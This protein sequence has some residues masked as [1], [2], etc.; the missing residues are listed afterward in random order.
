[1]K[2]LFTFFCLSVVLAL[3]SKAQ[4]VTVA[5][6][7]GAANG[8]YATLKSAFDALN[9]VTT[10]AGNIITVSITG[11]TTEVASAALNQPSVSSWTS[12]T[13][14]PSGGAARTVSGAITG[15]LIDLNGTQN[16][17]VNGLNTG[18]NSLNISNIGIGASSTIRLAADASNNTVTNC[19]LE[20]ST[21]VFGVV[22]LG[23]G[24][25]TGNDGNIISSNNI[26]PAGAN[27][28]LNGI[29]SLGT[30]AVIDNSGNTITA[31]NI[32]DYFSATSATN[33]MN[34]N[35]FNSAWTITN[36]RL[37]QTSSRLYTTAS[38]HNGINITSG[39]NY[40]ITGNI[41]GFAN[42]AGTGTT[43]MVGNTVTL[44]GTFPSSY[45]TTG[46]ANATRYVAINCAFTAG[47][48]VSSIQNN[49][50]AG[51]AL[52]T[53]S[54]ATT[55]NG[56][57]CGINVTSGN[58]DIGT[59]AGNT[60]GSTSGTGSIYTAC[61]TSGG[62]VVGIY[63]STTNTISIQNNTIGA[64]DAMGTTSSI[65]GGFNGIN[66]AGTGGNFDIS[67]NTIGNNT[68]PNI[69]TGNL[70]TGANL[71]NVGTTNGLVTGTGVGKVQGIF[72]AAS[73]IVII[74]TPAKPNTIRNMFQNSSGTATSSS[75]VGI[76][77]TAS[78]T[79]TISNNSI[80]N[81]AGM[82]AYATLSNG[83]ASAM[84]IMVRGGAVSGSTII[85]NTI[86]NIAMNN[87]GAIGT[88]VLGIAIAA[89][90]N[91]VVT[92]NRIY[93]LINLSTS[94]TA[95]APGAA[96]GI[97][98]RSGAVTG[99]PVNINNNMISLGNAQTTNTSFIGIWGQ[100]G[101]TP[102]PINNIYFNSVNIEGTVAAGAQ[103]SFCFYRGDFTITARV[104]AVDIRNNIFQNTRTGG[105]GGHYA[106]SNGFGATTTSATGWAANASNYNVL[107]AAA[108]SIGFWTTAQTFAGWQA[109]SASDANSISGPV[110]N[111]VSTPTADLHILFPPSSVIE[112]AGILIAA[113]TDDFDGQTRSTLSPTDIGADAGNFVTAGLNMGAEALVTPAVAANGCY[114]STETVTIRIRN[115][116]INPINFVTN[117]VTVTT[118]V[119]GAATQTLSAV[120]NTGTLGAGLSMDVPMVGTLNMTPTGVY[121]FNAFTAVTG[122]TNP[123]NDAMTPVNLTKAALAAGSAS[124]SPGSYCITGGTPTLTTTG[125]TGYGGLQWQEST[126]PSVGF[127]NISG[128]TTNPFTL[129][130]PITQTMYYRLQTS[131]N[132][133]TVTSNEVTVILNNPQITS[134]TPGA[135][136]GPGPVT[137]S[138]AAT[139]TGTV[140]NWYDVPSGGVSIGTGSPF[141]TPPI[142]VNTPYYVSASDGGGTAGLGLPAQIAG[143][144]GA[145]T[146]NFGLVFDA[147]A[148]FTLST[149]V[150][151]P[152][153]SAAG[154]AGTVTIDV[155]NSAGA[156][157]NT[158]TVAVVGNPVA[159]ATAQTVTLNF[160][161]LAGTNLKLRPG[162][163]SAGITGLLFEPSAGAPPGGNY[164]YPFVLSGVV[165]INHSTLTAPPTNT[166]RLDLYYYF[167]NWQII[168]G[169]ESARTSV[170]ASVTTPPA[171]TISYAGTPYCSNAGTATVTQTGTTGGT[172]SAAPA[173][174][175]INASTGDITL[176]TSTAGTYTVTYTIAAAG[177]CPVFTTTSS[178]T[179]T[180]ATAATISYA[181]SPY[182]TAGG[183]ATVTQTGTAGGT[184]SS[185]AGLTINGSTGDVTLGTSTPGTYT[186]TYTIA[187]AGGCAQFMTT[188]SITIAADNTITFTSA[189][190]TDAQTVCINTA[191]T[192][193]T[194]AT[195]GATGATF[196]G[197]PAGVTG[198]WA[199]NVA[200][201]SGSPTTTVGSPFSYTVTLT[202]GCGTLSANGT[203]TVNPDNTITLTSIP[204]TD[205]QSVC[206]NTPIT[207]IT[208]STTGATG[209]TFTGLPAGVTGSWAANV[210]TISG[211]PT[212]TVGS[213]FNYT[214]TLT[215]G[216]GV[217]TATGSIT[218]RPLPVINSTQL[219]PTTCAS[220]DGSIDI[221]VSGAA[222]PYTYAWT[223]SG[224]NP[225]SEDQTGLTVG[226]YS[227]TATAANG[228]TT[229]A[230]FGL[231]GPGGCSICPTIGSFT[232]NPSGASCSG[233]PLTLTASGLTDMGT[234][235]GIIFKQSASALPDPYVGGTVVA[236]IPNGALTSGGTVATTSTTL[237]TGSY[238]IYAILTPTPVDPVCRPSAL[239]NHTVGATPTV[240]QPA[241][242]VVC[243]NTAT[244]PVN[245]TGTPFGTICGTANEGGSV[246]LTAPVGSVI[247]N[248]VFASYGT[249]NGV[250]GSFTLGGCHAAN[251]VSIV[252]GLAVGQ[253][254]VIIPADNAIFGDPCGGTPKRLYI[255]AQYSSVVFNWT[256]SNPSIGLAASGTGNIPSF[257]ATN[258]TTSPVVATVT[259]TPE[260]SSAGSSTSI[261]MPPQSAIFASNARGYW[262]IAPV[263]FTI[264][265]LFVPTDASAGNQSIAVVR[266]DGNTPPPVFSTVTNA[267]STLF[268]TQND[269]TPGNIAVT[270]P[271]N[272][273]EVIGILGSRG[274]TSS[275]GNGSSGI[276]IAGNP[277]A[278]TRMGMQFPLT[279]TTPQDLWQ[280]PS[281]T[282]ISRVFFGYSLTGITCPGSSKTFTITVNPTPA[283]TISYTGS[284]YC[285]NA[286]TAT[287]TQ[288]GTAG[289]T[290]SAAPAGLILNAAN[291]D[292]TLGTST[293]GTYTVTYTIAA[294]GGCPS[295]TATTSITITALPAATINYAGNPYCSNAGTA[296]VT[297][298]GTAGGTYSA[299]PA[300]L[301]LNA[302]TGNV[303]LGTSTPGTY[304][305]TYTIAA[306]GGCPAVTATTSI[307]ITA[308][309]A[310]TINYAGSPYCTSS[311]TATVTRTGIAGGT[312]TAT[313]AGLTL[314][315][316]TG[317]VT[318]ATSA[319]GTYTVTYT[320]AASGGCP[321]VTATASITV[322][323]A[324]AATIS[325]AGTPYC[326][327][328]PSAPV[329]RTGAAG[330]TYTAAPAGLT[331]NAS[332]GTVTPNTS[333]PGT[334]TVT[335]SMVA[336][337]G[338]PA[339]TATTSIT[340][341]QAPNMIIF[342]AGTPYCSNAGT[343]T[344]T[345]FGTAGGTYSA[346]P[347]GL[348]INATTGA[349]TLGTSTPG[350][351]TVTY[352][353]TVPGC[354]TT[355]T[356]T[357][358]TITA[359]PNATI[360]YAGS[361]YCSNGGTAA[362]TQTGTAGGTYSSTAGLTLNATTGAVTLG[363]SIPGTYTVTYTVAA[364]GGCAAFATTTT[365]T[366]TALPAAT[367]AYTGSPYCQNAGTANVT[368]AGT[369][370]GTYT[371]AAG[372]SINA[373]TGAVNLAASTAGT[374][375]VTYTLAA[376]G[377]CPA[378]T[379]TTTITITTLPAATIT[380]A[381]NPYCANGGTATVTRTGTAGGTYT[382]A[383]AGLGINV[384]TGAVTL[385]TSTPGTYT[386]TY[387]IA[388]GGG[389]G[390]VTAT[391]SIT[392]NALSVDPTGATASSTTICG[393]GTV[394]LNVTGGSLGGG[395]TWRWYSGSC[396][397]TLVG[398]GATLNVTVNATTTYFV[399]AEGT[400]N[401]TACASA[402]VTV[403]TQP[404]ISISA[405]AI[406]LVFPQ[407][408]TLTATVVPA[409]TPV[410]WFRNGVQVPGATGTT[411][412]VSADAVGTY[413]ARATTA[414]SCTAL[415]NA[416]TITAGV[417]DE[418]FIYPNPNNGQFTVKYHSSAQQLG[419]NRRLI[420]YNESGQFVY[421]EIFVVT[422]PYSS[423]P[424][425][426]R[427]LAKGFYTLRVTDA[428]GNILATGKVITQ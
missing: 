86:N 347:A 191:I 360:S 308:L 396:G 246:T 21:T 412:V 291:G 62:I 30:S 327:S 352:S 185:T 292:V 258:V 190:G 365:I 385:G 226:S 367:I 381:A 48:T 161:I 93:N 105:T 112:A 293:P 363:T 126:T 247:T 322:T 228:C 248:I 65:T 182:C 344:V 305:V 84:G 15:H 36:N 162:S 20:G 79:I 339:A 140:L 53:S 50:I 298:T 332:T 113:I 372:L 260:I 266:F 35:S 392:V 9:L 4:N 362:V 277:V 23:T 68:N 115:S 290:Y 33:G 356:T 214:V 60:I 202:G 81:L 180:A 17:T 216:C 136:C 306:S 38:T 165:S 104:A 320:I 376:G 46:T 285:S 423:M 189:P 8:S 168:T 148:P 155:V 386:V 215:G 317:D 295:V 373:A 138:L 132:G 129:A 299:A 238:F 144:S 211:T 331:I 364:S 135:S 58:A 69:R 100:H 96:C 177:G 146:T 40:T 400:C 265:S 26:G 19:T 284:P 11:N 371:A 22:Y 393:S 111:F 6:S 304:T 297:R 236:T 380:Y 141:T 257:T 243:N 114:T 405:S 151:Y 90:T 278:T 410:V 272:A 150:V 273:G 330:G 85:S 357:T 106:I 5:G 119:T 196:T 418:L 321:A 303:T 167:Y 389:C 109:A 345:R 323:A 427:N 91:I 241:N 125:A 7:G 222:G 375:T 336:S 399:R 313:P 18:G 199:A 171:A 408:S 142:S 287:V 108:S 249:P 102:D 29:Y 97:L 250:C 378:V 193:I 279:T 32:F 311:G 359:A 366:I 416:V 31:N 310:A 254:S 164:G 34:I 210:V 200:T 47:G 44:T 41:I 220:A 174:L 382:A 120:V 263:N 173:G 280:E 194:Y 72:N 384:T 163:R 74:G 66:S 361:P 24:I 245:F 282:N 231:A 394:T 267:F 302:A 156:V 130:S 170:I 340:I 188:T 414:L 312:Y 348:T 424:V 326:S 350:T 233:N 95:T 80:T 342:Y 39:V 283:A 49:T 419:F 420:I 406:N 51:F 186:V 397:G 110:V 160:N 390:V 218:V 137:V 149:V 99:T 275:Y 401:N 221:T 338:C 355:I 145:G 335:Y 242:Q 259:V 244:A 103:P 351:Y 425:D 169:C 403:N 124:V 64:I 404:T 337:G 235:Y 349:V 181:G 133:N 294:S 82:N 206:L 309:A 255:E 253:N 127:T 217:I 2:K 153:A 154:T 413:T 10:Q 172:Y 13:I 223:G 61:T 121:T 175:S 234:T 261:T 232:S 268:I 131:C 307:T 281:S 45:T 374:Y 421:N 57:L 224:V 176:G 341:T 402:T 107:N 37:Y 301:T 147:L 92:R 368:R 205:A 83:E 328:V 314:N 315:A 94:V 269:V 426:I 262:F 411:L 428:F 237:P 122:D 55:T 318:L 178:I 159:T 183:T 52:Y 198:S 157:L 25:V 123:G 251:S 203:I 166:P 276:I 300:G 343:A 346:T 325:Y 316:T 98:I 387:T 78:G 70:T 230:S 192:N 256:N 204:G 379:A 271:V 67:G 383:P 409:G 128:A 240:D 89:N 117:P 71:S 209:A 63:A 264:T 42:S 76:N 27:N 14:S 333:I 56:I 88:N 158:A 319:A 139:G 354:G 415:S 152:I 417:S 134:T 398:T 252:S 225:I 329:T 179:V 286:G 270:I 358:V 212:T 143:T 187:A 370:G 207:N 296:T 289:G 422:G 229:T 219:E 59:T 77:S 28:P 101:S 324:N 1:M 54:G 213:P 391:T 395:A 388:A 369:A 3:T 407:T 195:T 353:V 274:T 227:V 208:Y 73:G 239:V 334:Y 118:N 75:V 12:L 116:D 16:V 184:Y 288:T 87:T 197:L 201:I 43:N 377:G